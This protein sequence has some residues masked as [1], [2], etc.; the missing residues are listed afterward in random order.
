MNKENNARDILVEKYFTGSLNESEGVELENYLKTDAKF[1]ESFALEKSIRSQR[2]L[3]SEKARRIFQ[4][5]NKDKINVWNSALIAA[6]VAGFLLFTF[7]PWKHHLDSPIHAKNPD[8][9]SIIKQPINSEDSTILDSDIPSKPKENHPIASIDSEALDHFIKPIPNK[10]RTKSNSAMVFYENGDF[11]KFISAIPS[12]L[13]RLNG[14]QKRDAVLK[15]GSAHLLIGDYQRADQFFQLL[16]EDPDAK[17]YHLEC[18]YQM[19]CS[20]LKQGK[21]ERGILMLKSIQQSR[22]SEE[23]KAILDLVVL[24]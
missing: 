5:K 6:T 21:T 11:K 8:S 10:I 4:E 2:N 17:R 16:I 19:S 18:K 15:L 7:A 9:A 3:P 20:L 24:N 13:E 22:K 1:A 23:V 12:E 14:S